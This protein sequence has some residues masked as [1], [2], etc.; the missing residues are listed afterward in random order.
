MRRTRPL[1]LLVAAMTVL[2]AACGGSP[3]PPGRPAVDGFRVPPYLQNLTTGAVTILW[4]SEDDAAGRL[5]Y[6]LE[7]AASI[8]E[9]TSEPELALALHY[10]AADTVAVPRGEI[11]AA[12]FRHRMRLT[13]LEPD[14]VYEYAVEQ[15]ESRAGA[16]F[17]TAPAEPRAIRFIAFSDSETEPES[18]GKRAAWPDPA[19]S[20]GE[21]RYPI[22]QTRGFANN[23]EVIWE[24]RPDFLA[25]AGDLVETGGEQR[26]WD[27]FWRHLTAPENTPG[28]ARHLPVIAAP[29]NHEYYVGVKPLFAQPYSEHALA[30]FRTYFEFPK[31]GAEDP[32]QEGRYHRFD[33]GPI[34]VI[35][36]DVINQ[37]PHG[38]DSDSSFYLRGARDPGGGHAPDFAP[39]SRQHAWLEEQLADAQSRSAFTF[40]LFHINPYTSGKHGKP[41][42]Q[43]E[44]LD[45]QSGLPVRVL[46]PLL[47]RYGVDAVIA[48]HDEMWE[49]SEIEGVEV[50]PEGGERPHAIH[51]FDVGTAGD[52]LR[53]PMAGVENPFRRFLAHEDAPEVWEGGVLVAGGKHYGHLEV[54]VTPLDGGG[55]QAE[56]EAVYVLPAAAGG[57]GG[58]ERRVYDDTVVLTSPG[59]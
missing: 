42:G 13:G 23:L 6:G 47:M 48:G 11:P 22:D 33:Y 50:L 4:F 39:G 49:R 1:W 40:L 5:S 36:V 18:T 46:T 20:D 16:T 30:R 38:S 57:E 41:P 56:L 14:T 44:G 53:G 29:G 26:D 19:G 17:R 9:V 8:A 25:I 54:D 31:N 28:V 21:R 15:G 32:E 45:P 7:G 12:P 34:T 27:E 51:F 3:A 52:G 2:L 59:G 37:S 24:R 35:A 55:W 10:S 43:G 58:Y